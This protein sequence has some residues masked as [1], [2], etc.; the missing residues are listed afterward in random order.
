MMAEDGSFPSFFFRESS[1]RV[2]E[3]EELSGSS[4]NVSMLPNW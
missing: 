2:N 3:F 4:F 1:F